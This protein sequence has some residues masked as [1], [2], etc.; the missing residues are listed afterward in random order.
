[1]TELTATP[2]EALSIVR[3]L[4]RLE[5]DIAITMHKQQRIGELEER[6]SRT[7]AI[8]SLAVE[9]AVRLLTAATTVDGT[10]RPAER[11]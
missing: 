9:R 10:S 1:M 11:A 8:S 6:L 7:P 2:D 5:L 3:E 4:F